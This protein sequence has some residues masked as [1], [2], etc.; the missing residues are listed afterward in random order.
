MDGK[1]RVAA[2]APILGLIAGA[3][4]AGCSEVTT[5]A[6][7]VHPVTAQA[8]AAATPIPDVHDCAMLSVGSPSKFQCDGKTYT[9]FQ[10]AKMRMDAEKKYK[11]GK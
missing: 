5:P 10:L 6:P 4:F 3:M 8:Q 9:S 1:R 7:A 2:W 11:S